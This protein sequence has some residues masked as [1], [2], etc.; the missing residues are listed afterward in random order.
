MK[1]HVAYIAE[2]ITSVRNRTGTAVRGQIKIFVD[3]HNNQCSAG[4]E[5]TV[6]QVN[7]RLQLLKKRE[8]K[9]ANGNQDD[10]ADAADSDEDEDEDIHA[11]VRPIGR[12][13]GTTHKFRNFK[14]QVASHFR[15]NI[16]IQF[17]RYIR[18]AA[19]DQEDTE[20]NQ[21]DRIPFEQIG[22]S[23]ATM[24]RL[25]YQDTL[26]EYERNYDF[27]DKIK[28]FTISGARSRI[29]RG[30]L[31]HCSV[32]QYSPVAA[33]EPYIAQLC[34]QA[35]RCN[36][37][38][39]S[40]DVRL[41][42]NSIIEGSDTESSIKIWKERNC[43]VLNST[44]SVTSKL[45][46][47]WFKGFMRRFPELDFKDQKNV[48]SLR[49]SWCNYHSLKDMYSHLFGYWTEEGYIRRL[50]MAQWQDMYGNVV[51][52][53]DPKRMGRKVKYEWLHPDRMLC[54]DEVGHNTN[55][56]RDKAAV[57]KRRKVCERGRGVAGSVPN[58]ECHFTS[59]CFT[60]M[61]GDPVIMVVIIAGDTSM[62][63]SMSKQV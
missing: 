32:G 48:N 35:S 5:V 17:H 56:E 23:Q 36:N 24:F 55:S 60:T 43:Y 6:M 19:L 27:M 28:E 37:S 52:V 22:S 41:M 63:G 40:V 25:I 42:A 44:S 1:V 59:F 10:A 58:D 14:K 57:S 2:L 13:N 46:Y 33:A 61:L 12:P 21:D 9:E 38:L 51:G 47:S 54:A 4:Q 62:W 20:L 53:D 45:G 8:Q 3:E 16:T 29:S 11:V 31:K 50:P 18:C 34:I 15:D 49:E 7:K 30:R 39:S 26:K